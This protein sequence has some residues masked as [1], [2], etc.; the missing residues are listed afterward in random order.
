MIYA[1]HSLYGHFKPAR[2]GSGGSVSIWS[3]WPPILA[4]S[5]FMRLIGILKL[6]R[7]CLVILPASARSSYVGACHHDADRTAHRSL[8]ARESVASSRSQPAH[9][10]LLRLQLR[11]VIRVRRRAAQG[12]TI[13]AG[14]GTARRPF[15]P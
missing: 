3:L 10:R 5:I 9:L 15:D 11:T 7:S 6:R 12:G 4:T 8:P 13:G 1:I 14:F 2:L